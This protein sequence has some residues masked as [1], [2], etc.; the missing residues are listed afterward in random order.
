MYLKWFTHDG[1]WLP[2]SAIF[3]L[4]QMHFTF[5]TLVVLAALWTVQYSDHIAVIFNNTINLM[6]EFQVSLQQHGCWGHFDGTD[7][8][9]VLSTPTAK[10]DEIEKLAEWEKE[11]RMARYMLSQ[12]LPG[13]V[14]VQ[15]HKLGTVKKKWDLVKEE[16][17]R[18]GLFAQANL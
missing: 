12:K 1:E 5:I 8:K 4:L 9:P 14:I 18:K 6:L 13:S 10:P 16:Y 2:I 11:E 3:V 15:V 7:V 17:T